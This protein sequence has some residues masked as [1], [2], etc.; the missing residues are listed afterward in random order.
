MNC[1]VVMGT[2][3]MI[4]EVYFFY[5]SYISFNVKLATGMAR[6]VLANVIVFYRDKEKKKKS[7]S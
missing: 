7:V 2:A 4:S 6:R 1:S 3:T 5:L